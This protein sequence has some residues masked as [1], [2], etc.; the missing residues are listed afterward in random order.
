M[1]D[2]RSKGEGCKG[3]GVVEEIEEGSKLNNY[4]KLHTFSPITPNSYSDL[5]ES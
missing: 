5:I 1:E 2:V 3:V 4:K